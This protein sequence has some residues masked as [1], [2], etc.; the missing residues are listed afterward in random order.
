MRRADSFEKTLM[1]GKIEGRRRR[2]WQ[3]MRWLDGITDAMDMNLSK[4]Q[5]FMMDRKAWCAVVHG[6]AE[7]DT[8]EQLNWTECDI[9]WHECGYI[10]WQKV[11]DYFVWWGAEWRV[12]VSCNFSVLSTL[13]LEH[14]KCSWKITSEYMNLWNETQLHT[15]LFGTATLWNCVGRREST[16]NF[17]S[18][19][20]RKI[21]SIAFTMREIFLFVVSAFSYVEKILYIFVQLI[22]KKCFKKKLN[23]IFFAR[24]F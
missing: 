18:S 2:G 15:S 17:S 9:D 3:I 7:S 5:E 20:C 8:T 14:L 23:T 10:D 11:V 13:N 24:L 19:Y 21:I 22:A 1:L 6:V 16:P 4:L 12:R